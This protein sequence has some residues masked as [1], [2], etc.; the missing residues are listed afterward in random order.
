MKWWQEP[1]RRLV[2]I[3]AVVAGLVVVGLIN[4]GRGDD[5]RPARAEGAA[6][7]GD[8]RASAV[9]G[10][11]TAETGGGHASAEPSRTPGNT[12]PD[13]V[14]ADFQEAWDGAR[15][16]GYRFVKSHDASGRGR[17]QFLYSSW[18]VCDQRPG[19]GPLAKE[20]PVELG[21]VRHDEKC[22]SSAIPTTGPEVVDGRTPNLIGRSVNVVREAL[23]GDAHVEADDLGGSRPILVETHWMVCT[24]RP[25]AGA[26]LPDRV[27]VGVVKYGEHCP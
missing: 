21:V 20:L 11:G 12:L 6:A 22:P 10:Q 13:L 19:P 7:A 18:K 2:V 14:G 27:K 17:R 15:A 1:R 26:A 25:A 8:V 9:A 3:C 5:D 16:A 24:Q 4:R 23:R